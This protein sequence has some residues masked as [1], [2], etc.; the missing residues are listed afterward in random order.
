MLIVLLIP[1]FL[2]ACATV[3]QTVSDAARASGELEATKSLPEYPADCRRVERSG[4]R[5]GERLDTALIRTDQA[6]GRQ[7]AR[8][9][10]CA[11]WYDGIRDEFNPKETE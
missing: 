2:T 4:V 1:V 5:N 7:N 8:V 10:R 11:D 9:R 3:D 6:L